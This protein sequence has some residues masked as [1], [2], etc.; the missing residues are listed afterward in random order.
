MKYMHGLVN[1]LKQ[2]LTRPWR[3][4]HRPLQSTIR[5][6]GDTPDHR[7]SAELGLH[8]VEIMESF[9]ISARSAKAIQFKSTCHQPAPL[10]AGLPL[11]KL[12]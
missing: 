9:L 7:A 3:L 12:S 1:A 6:L 2:Q 4:N 8:V 11:G 5:T 10:P